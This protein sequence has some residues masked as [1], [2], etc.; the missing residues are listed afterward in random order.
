MKKLLLLT[1]LAFCSSTYAGSFEDM[2]KLDKEIKNLKSELNL[3]YKKAYSQTEAKHELDDA[4]KAWLKF[5]EQ[6]CGDFVVADT[7]G[8][9][10]TGI[11][12]LTCQSILYKH[13]IE[14][15]KEMF[16]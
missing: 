14:F 6:Q 9:P 12:D 16:N 4:Q 13:R 8:S 3:V 11:Y 7:Q 5:K 2:Q 15:F 1:T 10:A